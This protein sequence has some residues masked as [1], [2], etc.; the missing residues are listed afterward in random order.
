MALRAPHLP[1]VIH[2]RDEQTDLI[3]VLW[4]DIKDDGLIVDRI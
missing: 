1:I 3:H 2:N 4:R